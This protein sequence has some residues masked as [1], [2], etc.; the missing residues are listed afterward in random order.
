M[1]RTAAGYAFKCKL[2]GYGHIMVRGKPRD[3]IVVPCAWK[4]GES[5]QYK[6]EDFIYYHGT[7]YFYMGLVD[8][9]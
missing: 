1:S 7:V 6:K 9:K 2:C 5:A 4:E 8:A 3:G